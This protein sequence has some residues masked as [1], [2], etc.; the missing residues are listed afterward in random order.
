MTIEKVF[1]QSVDRIPQDESFHK[2]W[3]GFGKRRMDCELVD[4]TSIESGQLP[5]SPSTLVVGGIRTVEKAMRQIGMKT[6]QANNL[7]DELEPYFGRKIRKTTLGIVRSEWKVR[8]AQSCFLKPLGQNKLFSALA[9]F[10]ADDLQ[11]LAKHSDETPV[12][13]SDYVLF[14]SEWRVFVVSGEIVGMSNYQGDCLVY[15][16]ARTIKAAIEDFRTAPAAYGIDFGVLSN[17]ET[18]LVEAND[19]YSLGSYCLNP[20]DYSY[21]LEA[22]WSEL[23]A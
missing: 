16:S 1:V 18:V 13:V 2:A 9:L 20:V 12:I 6:P 11:S 15:P 10:G 7:P 17:G 8:N 19:G 14:D 23:A 4:Q 21:L 5:L 22:R 3:L